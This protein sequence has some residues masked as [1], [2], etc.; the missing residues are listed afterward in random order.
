MRRSSVKS[1]SLA[2]AA[3]WGWMPAV[4]EKNERSRFASSTA[5]SAP[6]MPLPSR[7]CPT[8]TMCT[9]PAARARAITSSRSAYPS[10]WACASTSIR[11][12]LGEQLPAE[13]AQLGAVLRGEPA[14]K[15]EGRR[16]AQLRQA[17]RRIHPEVLGGADV[18]GDLQQ[19]LL[20]A[21]RFQPAQGA[22]R[23]PSRR[24]PFRLRQLGE[25]RDGLLDVE[26]PGPLCRDGPVIPP[27]LDPRDE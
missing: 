12:N 3:S 8:R 24:I 19:T 9:S 11:L 7:H 25:R 6:A 26:A 21:G 15:L 5:S 10:R 16:R 22:D 4:A 20:G 27:R 13:R 18:A 23:S 2:C 1:A 14:Q 17:F